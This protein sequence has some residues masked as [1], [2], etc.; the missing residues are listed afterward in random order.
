MLKVL[1]GIADMLPLYSAE[2]IEQ[3]QIKARNYPD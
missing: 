2:W 3:W 1:E